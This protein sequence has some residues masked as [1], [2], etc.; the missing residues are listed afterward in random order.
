MKKLIIT[1]VTIV[2]LISIISVGLIANGSSDERYV[3]GDVNFDGKITAEDARLV[4]RA[5]VGLEDWGN[6]ETEETTIENVEETTVEKIEETTIEEVEE[7]TIENVE[8]T[9]VE[10]I[11]ETTIEEVE[12]TTIEEVE[13]CI[14]EWSEGIITL[15][16]TCEENGVKTYTCIK[17]GEVK[18]EEIEALGHDYIDHE[19]KE[20]TCTDGGWES[21]QTCSRCDYTTYKETAALGHTIETIEVKA[22]CT[23]NGYIKH[24]CATCG[25]EYDSETTEATGHDWKLSKELKASSTN[26]LGMKIYT[27]SVCGEIKVETIKSISNCSAGQTI[28]FGSYPQSQVTDSTLISNLE[29]VDGEWISYGYYTGDGSEDGKMEASDYMQYKDIAYNGVKYRAVKITKYRPLNTSTKAT[30]NTSSSYQYKFGYY[31]DNTY[32]FKYEPIMWTVVDPASGLIASYYCLDSQAYNNYV[33]FDGFDEYGLPAYYGDPDKI[34]YANDYE[35]SSIREWLNDDFYNTAFTLY[36]KIIISNTTLEDVNVSDKIFLPTTE[37]F[38]SMPIGT[39]TCYSR[40][41]G[42]GY[43]AHSGS[44]DYQNYSWTRE[45]VYNNLSIYAATGNKYY[46]N[47]CGGNTNY[48]SSSTSYNAYQTWIGVRPAL[49]INTNVEE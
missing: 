45:Q 27:C 46:T 26:S 39:S 34:Y 22:T 37:D 29:K 10:K 28:Y 19:A 32:W 16:A 20:A 5:A 15:D 42:C 7:T 12:E 14:H 17:C 33:L 3:R 41:Q 24:V 38:N 31:V 40:C 1:I 35:H 18:T 30:T 13:E 25:E 47:Y 9:T 6:G 36:E 43:Y 23:E 21:Y 8:E 2:T 4:L 11:E 48:K 49:C 44:Y